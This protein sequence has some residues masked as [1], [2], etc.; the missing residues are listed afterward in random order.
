MLHVFMGQCLASAALLP[1][2]SLNAPPLPGSPPGQREVGEAIVDP[3]APSEGAIVS[4][5]MAAKVR[6]FVETLP[7]RTREV[8]VRYY[9]DE[10]R[11]EDIAHDL[12]ISQSAVAHALRRAH[13]MGRQYFGLEH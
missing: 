2:S 13:A 6:A 9:W 4:S 1:I 7:P 8:V 10:E 11:Q 12:G 3:I 5:L